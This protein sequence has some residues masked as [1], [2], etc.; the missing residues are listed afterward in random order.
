MRL[1]ITIGGSHRLYARQVAAFKNAGIQIEE[2][3]SAG[4]GSK[5]YHAIVPNTPEARALVKK[6]GASVARKQWSWLSDPRLS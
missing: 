5:K 1:L 4:I 2:G 6:I 3:S